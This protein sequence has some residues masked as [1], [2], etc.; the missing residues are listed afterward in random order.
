MRREEKNEQTRGRILESAFAE[1]AEH[2]YEAGSVNTI[3]QRGGLSKGIIYHYFASK[4]GLYLACVE[5]CFQD[6]TD[7]LAE[8]LE[9]IRLHTPERLLS[10]YF[11]L[12]MAYFRD[13]RDAARI[14]CGAVMTPPDQLREEIA[15]RKGVLDGFNETIL[16]EILRD[17]RLRSDLTEE[18]LLRTFHLFQDL[19]SAGVRNM[20][21]GAGEPERYEEACRSALNIF[22][23]GIIE[24]SET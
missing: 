20:D 4:D 16:R 14:F 7:D 11:D 12:R 5:K 21:G 19:L 24:R 8:H 15:R 18:E 13:H 10:A 17:R 2:G 9:K 23:Y 6:L 3:C 1:F 22:L